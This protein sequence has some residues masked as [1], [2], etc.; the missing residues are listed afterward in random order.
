MS[1]N[2]SASAWQRKRHGRY[3]RLVYLPIPDVVLALP[4]MTCRTS[5]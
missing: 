5:Q 4:S 1:R 3:V 2:C